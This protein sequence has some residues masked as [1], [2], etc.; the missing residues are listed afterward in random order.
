[1]RRGWWLWAIIGAAVLLTGP[2]LAQR[3]AWERDNRTVEI[4]V[5]FDSVRALS[6]LVGVPEETILTE[7]AARGVTAVGV[8]HPDAMAV[9]ERAGLRAAP[10]TL[11]AL[12]AL[13]APG[14]GPFI[15]E[16]DAVQEY[17]DLAAVARRLASAGLPLGIVE[18]D[19][20]PGLREL[21]RLMDDVAVF[22]HSIPPDELER[23]TDAQ[24]LARFNRAMLERQA[25][26]LYVYALLPPALHDAAGAAP[27]AAER[28]ALLARNTAFVA[29]LADRV[30]QLDLA[31]GPAEP[32][33]RWASPGV[34][35]AAVLIAAAAGALLAARIFVRVNPVWELAAL[36][37]AVAAAAALLAGE[38]DVLLRQAAALAVACVFPALAVATATEPRRQAEAS[39]MRPSSARVVADVS[40][41]FGRA[42][43]VTAAAALLVAAALTDSRFFLKLEQF[44]G[45]KAAHVLPMALAAAMWARESFRIMVAGARGQRMSSLRTVVS[46]SV[47]RTGWRHVVAAAVVSAALF[48]L[49]ART[50]HHLLPVSA[51]ERAAREALEKWL[52]VRPRT[53]EFLLGYPALWL[54]LARFARGRPSAG[55]PF[56]VAGSVAS[57]SVINTF[58]HAH[59]PLAV[60]VV[61]SVYGM[62]LGSAAAA[63]AMA[64]LTLWRRQAAPGPAG[65]AESTGPAADKN[66]MR[67]R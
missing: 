53:K 19:D 13:S 50:G 17:P 56:I 62:L 10:R 7:W 3:A 65:A 2:L 22:V 59:V 37:V 4:A 38:R 25:R 6:L 44:R 35:P 11:A 26:V 49:V 66:G 36:G 21:A 27:A 42:A 1:M 41:R 54:G 48:V 15:P 60:S 32:V 39:A 14:A 5:D 64:L 23:L 29:A 12:D 43:L 46:A 52:V 58:A 24:A 67:F 9:A 55:W 63:A 28:E 45:V 30:R 47:R 33:H 8:A 31:I 16:E 61:R 51:W 34:V 57:V 20:Q 40:G 18:F